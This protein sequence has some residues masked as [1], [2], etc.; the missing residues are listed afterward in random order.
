[1]IPQ[2]GVLSIKH[3]PTNRGRVLVVSLSALRLCWFNR[4]YRP[5]SYIV[6]DT[7]CQLIVQMRRSRYTDRFGELER[8]VQPVEPPQPMRQDNEFRDIAGG[9]FEKIWIHCWLTPEGVPK[10]MR[11][12][13]YGSSCAVVVPFTTTARVVPEKATLHTFD[14]ELFCSDHAAREAGPESF[15]Q[16]CLGD[17]CHSYSQ[18]CLVGHPAPDHVDADSA[19]QPWSFRSEVIQD[20]DRQSRAAKWTW[21]A[22]GHKPVLLHGAIALRYQG[23]PFWVACRTRGKGSTVVLRRLQRR[24]K[25]SNETKVPEWWQLSPQTSNMDLAPD[26]SGLKAEMRRLNRNE[27]EPTQ[28][29]QYCNYEHISIGGHARVIAGSGS[30]GREESNPRTFSG[31]QGQDPQSTQPETLSSIE[32]PDEIR[33]LVH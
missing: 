11:S 29:S 12:G 19:G 24:F 26:I 17:R 20:C 28:V 16:P 27:P 1:M 6:P 25:F 4:L 14:I 13:K 2:C 8:P 3:V 21:E 32:Q 31:V 18:P 15:P 7:P 10:G 5:F 9:K 33:R 22:H 23:G 30:F